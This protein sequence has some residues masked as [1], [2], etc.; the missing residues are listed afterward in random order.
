M[1]ELTKWYQDLTYGDAKDILKEKL[2]NMKMNFIAAGYY[3]KYIRDK[4]LYKEDGYSSIWEFAD[5]NYGIKMST[6]S[7]W[8]AMNDKFSEGGNTPIL[9]AQY[10]QFG[11]SQLQEMLYLEESKMA[12]ITPDMTVKEIRETRKPEPLSYYGT[13]RKVYPEDSL[14]KSEG[15]EGGHD[16][17]S[18][19]MQ[20]DIRQKACYCVEAPMVNPYPCMTMDN[21]KNINAV[22]GDRCQF[23][24]LQLA[25][26]RHGDELVPCCK[27][28]KNPCEYEC[29]R[30][31]AMRPKVITDELAVAK[32]SPVATSQEDEVLHF[33]DESTTDRAYGWTWAQVVSAYLSDGYK[34]PDKECEI[35][36]LGKT[37]KV[38]KRSSI[39]VFYDN[40]GKTLFDVE[41]KR[42]DHEYEFRMESEEKTR[43]A[44]EHSKCEIDVSDQQEDDEPIIDAEYQE[45]R[46]QAEL[47]ILKNNDQR[48][49]FIDSYQTWPVWIEIKETGEKYFRYNLQDGSSMVVKVYFHRCFDYSL[50][51]DR[52]EDR[53]QDDWG[54][55]EYY[56][57]EEGKYFKDCQVNRSFLVDKL[58]E[59]QKGENKRYE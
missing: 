32:E 54:S 40:T 7:R 52:Y 56:L 2:E 14:I 45:V 22:I 19:H 18:C 13:T 9:A 5:E 53:F 35:E 39:T 47:P 31:A 12:G 46:E 8:M 27:K 23:V 57:L 49:E 3:L 6:A 24:N 36:F 59:L 41:N 30:S 20:C 34:K 48:K 38:L 51:T 55:E 50:Q 43:L 11:K 44:M 42:L 1:D 25:E 10:K 17:F 4:E 15:C 16:C 21:Y 29:E 26:D 37:Y 58:K 33:K 28:C